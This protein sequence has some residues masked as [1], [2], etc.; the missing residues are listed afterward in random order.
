[1]YVRDLIAAGRFTNQTTNHKSRI[2]L[3]KLAGSDL[4]KKVHCRVHSS[5]SLAPFLSHIN[6]VHAL[7][8]YFFNTF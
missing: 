7:P 6:L 3:E 8:L 2:L 4:V 5:P 1:M